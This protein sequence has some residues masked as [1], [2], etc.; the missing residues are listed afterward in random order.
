MEEELQQLRDLV[1]QL[2]ADNERLQQEQ[3]GTMQ[4]GPSASPLSA[5]VTSPT[6]VS[7]ARGASLTERLV[8]VPRGRR[9]S[10]FNGRSGVGIS[11]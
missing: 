4:P 1:V 11:E 2:R 9:C 10:M 5:V 6:R 8:L 7:T 3:A